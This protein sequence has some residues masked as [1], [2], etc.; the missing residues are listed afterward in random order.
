MKP[1]TLLV[2]AFCACL[3]AS[4]NQPR[5][6]LWTFG[7]GMP[8]VIVL[9]R[10]YNGF[11]WGQQSNMLDV[12]GCAHAHALPVELAHCYSAHGSSSMAKSLADA[13]R[14]HVGGPGSTVKGDM[15]ECC[16][17]TGGSDVD[18]TKCWFN[19]A[20]PQDVPFFHQCLLEE[21]TVYFHGK[22]VWRESP[23]GAMHPGW[24]ADHSVTNVVSA[25]P[26]EENDEEGIVDKAVTRY[27]N[28]D[29]HKNDPAFTAD[30]DVHGEFQYAVN[31]ATIGWQAPK[32]FSASQ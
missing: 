27:F 28:D 13:L 14:G 8:N 19:P 4:C 1:L 26:F 7:H 29:D 21:R 11:S 9:E 2:L 25:V 24:I 16:P 10:A 23:Y 31:G 17:T 12:S 22:G 6:H 18:G 32:T 15:G 3:T 30:V 20:P 5:D